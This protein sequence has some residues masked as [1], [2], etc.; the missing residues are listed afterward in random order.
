MSS[1]RR[2]N[3]E[4]EAKFVEWD[5][6]VPVRSFRRR[7]KTSHF[8]G[9]ERQKQVSILKLDFFEKAATLVNCHPNAEILCADD[10]PKS[11]K[12][13]LLSPEFSPLS[14]SNCM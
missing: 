11:F 10:L 8:F 12:L 2:P 5:D 7:F 13:V 3:E 6:F 1:G 4:E 14:H 9:W